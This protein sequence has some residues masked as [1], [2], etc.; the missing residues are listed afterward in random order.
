MRLLARVYADGNIPSKVSVLTLSPQS[1]IIIDDVAVVV[2]F[3]EAQ[4]HGEITLVAYSI[5]IDR[6]CMFPQASLQG[7]KNPCFKCTKLAP[8]ESN[9]TT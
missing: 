2:E 5:G 3:H 1:M 7:R 6:N 9:Y 8:Q 4:V